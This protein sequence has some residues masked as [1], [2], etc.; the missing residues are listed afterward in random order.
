[1]VRTNL[2]S[3]ASFR[4]LE[5]QRLRSSTDAVQGVSADLDYAEPDAPLGRGARNEQDS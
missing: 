5:S 4:N 3:F 1:M 2:E